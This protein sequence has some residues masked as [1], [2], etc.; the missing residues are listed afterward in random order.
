MLRRLEDFRPERPMETDEDIAAMF[1]PPEKSADGKELPRE[2]KIQYAF[3]EW[4][5]CL[6]FIRGEIGM[7]RVILEAILRLTKLTLGV[8]I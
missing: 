2:T 3:D 7:T 4:L 8:I 5:D 6:G 1:S